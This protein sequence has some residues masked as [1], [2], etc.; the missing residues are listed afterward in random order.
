MLKWIRKAANNLLLIPKNKRVFESIFPLDEHRLTYFSVQE[1][2]EVA[3]PG[4]L[5]RVNQGDIIVVRSMINDLHLEQKI[6][7]FC[8]ENFGVS[9]ADLA[10]IHETKSLEDILQSAYTAR[11]HLDCLSIQSSV[12]A[13]I[14]KPHTSNYYLEL[15][16][17]LRLHLPYKAVK[18]KEQQI[19]A[20]I[21]RGK[22]NPHGQH[23]DSWRYHPK[24]TINVWIAL[25]EANENNG[26]ALL[27]DSLSYN[28]KFSEEEQEIAHG[29][30]TYPSQQW[31]GALNKGDAL[32]FRAELL[33]G[34]II[35][36]S[37][38]TRFA[39]SMRC[40]DQ[41]PEF[42]RDHQYN[43]I[44]IEN[45]K[46]KSLIFDKL[47]NSFNFSPQSADTHFAPADE[48][49]T[50]LKPETYDEKHITVKV[51]NEIM[52]FPRKCPHA[53]RDLLFGELDDDG[54]L[55]CPSH[56]MR[57]RGAAVTESR[58]AN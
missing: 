37:N 52:R 8:R 49:E 4:V 16:P 44:G 56:R 1:N 25:T 12:M 30:K 34:S 51:K 24:N 45:G 31:V 9:Y 35:N 14:L 18:A 10:S 48:K 19:E 15:Q 33:H 50:A 57:I 20:K 6:D 36:M 11:S 26:L 29:V 22:L 3:E 23:K 47:F 7:E 39:F 17:N 54:R 41:K 38:V 32:I 53:G 13:R 46:F 2:A 58:A 28:P 43:Y 5:A 27:P 21:G 55:L 42:H 40:T